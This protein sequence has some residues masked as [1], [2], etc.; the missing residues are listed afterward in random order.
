MA[1]RIGVFGGTFDPP[2]MGHL[3]LAA[4]ARAQLQLS[5]LLWVLAAVPP[6][7]VG[8]TISAVEDRLAMLRLAVQDEDSFE[9][10]MID[11]ERPGP[12][13]TLDTLRL[14]SE[15]NPGSQMILVIG[16]DSL[17]DLPDW[18]R[19]TEVVTACAEIGVMRR[20]G[21][22]IDLSA[23]EAKLPGLIAKVRFVDA[24]LLEISSHEIRERVMKNLPFKY[25]VPLAVHHFIVSHGL[26][27]TA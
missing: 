26:Y 27:Q 12:H 6:H 9:I 22:E 8:S 17:H 16:G 1:A 3:I 15:Q 19:P 20:P 24:P 7:K 14:L 25:Y 11:I 5:R 21:D 23:L 10:S 2:H 13:F 4:E 18:H